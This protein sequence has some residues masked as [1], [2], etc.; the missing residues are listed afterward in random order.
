VIKKLPSVLAAVLVLF[1]PLLAAAD[2]SPDLASR[3]E[4]YYIDYR[5]NDD[6]SAVAAYEWSVKVLKEAAVDGA[7]RASISYST[8]IETAEVL[9][10]YTRK[11]DGRRI[12]APKSN[13][14]VVVNK[15]REKDA[16]VFSD[17]TSLTAVFPEVAVGDSVVFAYRIS[18][19]EAMFPRQFSVMDSFPRSAAYDDVRVSLDAPLAL[20]VQHEMRG[21][22]E[23]GNV[24][25]DG[26]SHRQWQFSNSQPVKEKRQDWSVYDPSADQG[27]AF[28]TFKSYAEIAEAYAT[29]AR[30]KAAVTARVQELADQI[31][32][33]RKTPREQAHV[34]YDWVATKIGYAGN[35]IGVGAVVPHDIDFILDN[36]MGDCKDHATLLQALLAARGITSTQALVNAGSGYRLPKLP[37]VSYV[38]H[39][40]NYIPALDLYADSTS[41]TTPFGM[42]PF[43]VAGKPVLRVDGYSDSSRTPVAAPGSN[44][45]HI[46][47]ALKIHDDGSISGEVQVQLKG[48]FAAEARAQLRDLSKDS[49]ADLMESMFRNWGYIGSGDFLKDDPTA[50]DDSYAY[51]A[52]LKMQEFVQWPGSGAF[53]ITP[54]LFSQAP[55]S[56]FVSPATDAEETVEVT[57]SNGV[58]EEEYSFELPKKMKILALPEKADVSNAF[59]SYKAS[60]ALKGNTLLVKRV[61]DDRTPGNTCSPAMMADYRKFALKALQNLKSQVVYR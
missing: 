33:D 35:C 28:S 61:I 11:A 25:K 48:S 55:V 2:E 59:A 47:S 5:L 3:V 51:K 42:L 56:G 22:S 6:A 36:R 8:S 27:F 60:Y 38:N 23:T 26:R 53:L 40:I 15:G 44:R 41:A 34:L 7:K 54:L 52:S 43:A 45:Q 10:A 21:F 32:G 14:Q 18:Q 57:C 29:R 39:V 49:E 13:F 9:E 16:P 19:K 17:R 50:L 24:E 12:D 20:G 4:H 1:S 58:S 46:R 37:V 30:P 31:A